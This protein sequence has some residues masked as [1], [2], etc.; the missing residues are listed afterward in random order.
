MNRRPTGLQPIEPLY[1]P[2]RMT[3]VKAFVAALLAVAAVVLLAPGSA[4]AHPLGNFTVNRYAG[5]ELA[6]SNIYVRYALDLAEIPTYQLG[7]EV[8]A[9]GYPARLAASS[10]SRSTDAGR[11]CACSRVASHSVPA[12]AD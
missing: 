5:I 3:R 1:D 11:R 4:S 7:A 10:S 6:G 2:V 9:P 8:R 12:R